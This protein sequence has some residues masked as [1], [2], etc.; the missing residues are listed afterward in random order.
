MRIDVSHRGKK[1]LSR[2]LML[3]GGICAVYALIA[4]DMWL[5]ARSAY[6][7]GEKYMRW[8]EDP[9]AKKAELEAE[10]ADHKQQ[11]KKQFDAGDFSEDEYKERIE[12][13][14]FDYEESMKESSVKYAYIWF[15]TTVELF[16][17]PESRW[18]KLSREKMLLAKQKWQEEL[19]AKNIPFEPYMMD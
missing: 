17:K 7:E 16:A 11:A 4:G 8:Y 1:L 15:Q 18:V 19:K 10:L 2:A 12:I 6:Q 3:G 5:R 14:D 9:Q 13:L